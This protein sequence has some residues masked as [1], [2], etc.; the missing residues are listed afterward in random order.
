[1]KDKNATES[2]ER[3]LIGIVK[4][5]SAPLLKKRMPHPHLDNNQ[6]PMFS[7]S[8]KEKNRLKK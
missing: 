3:N 2:S 1:M 5:S 6:H 4:S 8:I 7:I